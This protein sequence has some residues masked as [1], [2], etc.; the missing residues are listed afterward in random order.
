MGATTY[1]LGHAHTYPDAGVT[2]RQS[3]VILHVDSDAA[4]LVAPGARSRAGGYQYLSNHGGTLPNG[5]VLTIAKVAK[6]VMASATEAEL[7]A[8]YM[9]A[10]GAVGLRDCLGAM[11]HAQPATPMGTG[12]NTANGA[13]NGTMG[14]KRRKAIDVRSYW[15]RGRVGQGQPRVSWD[16][17]KYNKGDSYAKHH[18]PTYH[19]QVRP[20]HTHVGGKPPECL[21]GCIRAMGEKEI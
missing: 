13:T 3:G 11:G 5:P 19:R 7:G 1:L 6:G 10:Q 8:L 15:V 12:N 16:A 21:Q 17:G 18:P 2:Y 20:I 4:Y 14:Q 9:G